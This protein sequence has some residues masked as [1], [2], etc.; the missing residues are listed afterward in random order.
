MN[1]CNYPINNKHHE[2]SNYHEVLS[3]LKI[4]IVITFTI[5]FL[6]YLCVPITIWP[7]FSFGCLHFSFS[8]DHSHK[9]FTSHSILHN[10]MKHVGNEKLEYNEVK[11]NVHYPKIVTFAFKRVLSS[12]SNTVV[13]YIIR[14]LQR[15]LILLFEW[16]RILHSILMVYLLKHII[17]NHN[18]LLQL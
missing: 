7:L 18:I 4:I 13:R 10:L 12:L 2:N 11:N 16:F 3:F 1:Q 5:S 9:L 14:N 8:I 17:G 6:P 15:A